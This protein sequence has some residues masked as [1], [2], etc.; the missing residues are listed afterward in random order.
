MRPLSFKRTFWRVIRS[1]R[2]C[3][4]ENN[5]PN[6]LPNRENLSVNVPGLDYEC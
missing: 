3:K 2:Y 4:T 5:Y 1:V 6:L